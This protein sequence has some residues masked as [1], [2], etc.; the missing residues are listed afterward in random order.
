MAQS[1]RQVTSW[2]QCWQAVSSFFLPLCELCAKPKPL[3]LHG[4]YLLRDHFNQLCM[5]KGQMYSNSMV[6]SI[7][8][9]RGVHGLDFAFF[10]SGLLLPPTGSGVKFSLLQPEPEWIWI[11]FC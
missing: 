9:T 4:L 3:S 2:F 5:T 1:D 10:E 8:P 11:L 6:S 7:V